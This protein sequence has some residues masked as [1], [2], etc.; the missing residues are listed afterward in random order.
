MCCVPE[1]INSISPFVLEM[2]DANLHLDVNNSEHKTCC[3]VQI[4]QIT[5]QRLTGRYL[6]PLLGEMKSFPV[7]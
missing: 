4:Y 2:L 1:I 6:L 3:T 5:V 7:V